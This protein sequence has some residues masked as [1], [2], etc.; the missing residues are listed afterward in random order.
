VRV[1]VVAN[2]GTGAPEH[3]VDMFERTGVEVVLAA[4]VSYRAE[5]EVSEVKNVC[6][7]RGVL[8]RQA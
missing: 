7:S 8:V 4:G 1:P 6:Q 3:F 2:S 5:V